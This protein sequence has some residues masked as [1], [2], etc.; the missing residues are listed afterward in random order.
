MRISCLAAYFCPYHSV[1]SI[2]LL[3]DQLFL[4]RFGK[5]GPSTTGIKFVCGN[6]Q[7][8]SGSDIYINAG[9]VFIP[10]LIMEAGSVAF[11]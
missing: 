3:C 11:F 4:N 5:T 8:F 1:S 9:A 2:F 7:R 10:E 6:K